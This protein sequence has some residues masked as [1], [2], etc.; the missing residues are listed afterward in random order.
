MGVALAEDLGGELP[1]ILPP[2][3]MEMI[4]KLCAFG[5][6]F[7]NVGLSWCQPRRPLAVDEPCGLIC[8]RICTTV[9]CM[10]LPLQAACH[11][12]VSAIT[13]Q[14]SEKIHV[15]SAILML[16]LFSTL[17]NVHKTRLC[18]PWV[19]QQAV[20]QKCLVPS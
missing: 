14:E 18:C 6:Q 20:L 9:S 17:L 16:A 10:C 12:R 5:L 19:Q 15:P 3:S 7:V 4:R 2:V 1:L 8:M 13:K 11:L